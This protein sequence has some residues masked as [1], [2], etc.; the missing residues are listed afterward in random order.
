[1]NRFHAIEVSTSLASKLTNRG[2]AVR[3]QIK[4]MIF[5]RDSQKLM[6]TNGSSAV[7]N[8]GALPCPRPEK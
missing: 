7:I 5:Q 8:V 3:L 1:M 2:L 6:T 4:A